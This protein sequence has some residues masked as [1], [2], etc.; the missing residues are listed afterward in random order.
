MI[1]FYVQL[2]QHQYNNNQQYSGQHAPWQGQHQ[3][4]S[5][6]ASA[7]MSPSP[8]GG[9]AMPSPPMMSN[10][11][12]SANYSSGPTGPSLPP[13]HP[14]VSLGLSKSTFSYDELAAATNG[15]A[16]ER[17]LGQGGFGYVHKGILPNGKEIAVKSLKSGSGQGEREFQAEVEIISRVHHRH[18]VSLVGYC[19]A[20]GQRMLVYEFVPN[21]TLEYHLHG[22]LIYI[23]TLFLLIHT[24]WF[25]NFCYKSNDEYRSTLIISIINLIFLF[26]SS[27]Y[28]IL[29]IAYV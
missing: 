2:G 29:C 28:Y 4:M 25:N 7:G 16:Q 6:Y 13:P 11:I 10:D 23:L 24:M 15:F 1:S 12:N 27:A 19:I 18:L 5:N 9:G 21:N 20:E 3:D 22:T 26:I 17:L 14:S 8:W